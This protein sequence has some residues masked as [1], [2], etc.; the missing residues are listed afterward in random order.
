MKGGGKR[1]RLVEPSDIVK[2]IRNITEV[3]LLDGYRGGSRRCLLS[4]GCSDTR[5][6][7]EDNH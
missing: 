5:G 2:G 6:F 4:K 3:V 7:E 1:V